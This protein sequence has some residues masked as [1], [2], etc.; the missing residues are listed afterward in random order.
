MD[1]SAL[2]LCLFL[3]CIGFEANAQLLSSAYS[4][5]VSVENDRTTSIDLGGSRSYTPP[6]VLQLPPVI[7]YDQLG[8][9]CKLDVQFERRFNF[10]VLFRLGDVQQVEAW[11]GKGPWDPTRWNE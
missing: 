6:P 4:F 7:N 9:F 8:I 10:P 3:S 1:R 2:L 5:P 11:E